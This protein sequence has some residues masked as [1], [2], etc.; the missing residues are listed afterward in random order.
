M[1]PWRP[2][3]AVRV[4][5]GTCTPFDLAPSLSLSLSVSCMHAYGPCNAGACER[6]IRTT[7]TGRACIR[8]CLAWSS[9]PPPWKTNKR[10]HS[11]DRRHRKIVVGAG[12][13]KGNG[14]RGESSRYTRRG[15]LASS[16]LALV[17]LIKLSRRTYV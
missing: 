7:C 5:L 14:R 4:Q 16:R 12:T 15:L 1:Y 2:T 10:D 6:Y 17:E 8:C 13:Y 9:S 3:H 11:V